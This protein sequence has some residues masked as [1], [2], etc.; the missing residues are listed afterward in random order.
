MEQH[1][2]LKN[3]ETCFQNVNDVY[4]AFEEFGGRGA[5]YDYKLREMVAIL[6]RGLK[7]LTEYLQE[8]EDS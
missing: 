3:A 1:K 4:N 2:K 5:D 6:S 8:S 7:N